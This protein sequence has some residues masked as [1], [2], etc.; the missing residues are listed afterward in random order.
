M[1]RH[2]NIRD[3]RPS[4]LPILAGLAL[5][6]RSES[7]MSAQICTD[8]AELLIQQLGTLLSIPGGRILVTD[9]DEPSGF[10][11][12]RVL[13]PNAF[14][15]VTSVF[16]E[17]IFVDPAHRRRGTGHALLTAVAQ[18]AHQAG[19]TNV[20]SVQIPGA[21]GVQRFLSRLGFAP[22]GGHRSVPTNVLLR[23][24]APEQPE[25]GSIRRRSIEELIAKRRR[26]R[27]DAA[28]GL[29]SGS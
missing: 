19:A 2:V 6:G 1:R 14:T 26:T 5:V 24:L 25:T 22:A 27:E 16:I 8:D 17:A 29:A 28:S 18:L 23:R 15:P 3:A 7:S 4:D 12:L 9:E 20:Y 21:R 11:L 13:E 10:V